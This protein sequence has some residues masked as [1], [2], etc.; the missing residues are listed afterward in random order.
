MNVPRSVWLVFGML[1]ILGCG[2]PIAN[3]NSKGNSIVCFGDSLTAG[4]GAD[5]G[6]DYP[7]FLRQKVKLKVYNAGVSGDTTADG[8]VRLEQDALD[9]NPKIV[10]ITL[11]ANDFLH[12]VP[13]EQI[14]KNMENIIDRIQ[15]QGAMVVW[16]TVKTGFFTD[17]YERDF[18]QLATR[19][20]ILLIADILKDIMYE[21]H[22]KYDQIHPNGAGYKFMADRI[23][24]AIKP[25]I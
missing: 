12:R 1:L 24:L 8:L 25:F 23:Y 11:G 3:I 2:K 17:A 15:K 18:K 9:K 16:A 19:K 22:Y 5:E 10:I 14:L 4:Y 21:P 6:Q 7:S 13:K 20:H